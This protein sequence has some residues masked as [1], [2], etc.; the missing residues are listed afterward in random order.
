MELYRLCL[1]RDQNEIEDQQRGGTTFVPPGFVVV[2]VFFCYQCR[3]HRLNAVPTV[4]VY[5]FVFRRAGGSDRVSLY[6]Y[7]FFCSCLGMSTRR[8]NEKIADWRISTMELMSATSS[9]CASL[10]TCS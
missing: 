4:N 8:F 6:F 2:V 9:A 10:Q 5:F 7:L 1:C 3:L